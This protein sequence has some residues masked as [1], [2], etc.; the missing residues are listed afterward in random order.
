MKPIMPTLQ[1]FEI[2]GKEVRECKSRADV[3]DLVD[4]KYAE[5]VSI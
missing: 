3:D 2:S 1:M 5:R 4:R